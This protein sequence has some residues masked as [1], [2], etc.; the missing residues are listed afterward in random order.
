MK[1]KKPRQIWKFTAPLERMTGRFAWSYVEFPHDVAKLFGKRGNVRVKCQINGVAVDR[2][3][4]PTK[5]GY[6]IIILGGDIRRAAK[7]KKVG[8]PVKV[9]V[10]LNTEPAKLDIP[11]ELAETLDF[12][13]E[14]KAAWDKLNPGMQRNM[15]YW[16]RSGKTALTRAKR[17]AELMRRLE[18]GDPFGGRPTR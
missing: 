10:W 17:I 3:L 5:S 16:V 7:I 18:T 15:C 11:E 13:P 14:M 4:M 9:E 6:H 8:E 2:A 12:I 1:A